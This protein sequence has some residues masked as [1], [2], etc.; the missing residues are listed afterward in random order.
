M[1]YLTIDGDVTISLIQY[2]GGCN[3]P[4]SGFIPPP[5]AP[6]PPLPTGV[7]YPPNPSAFP[8]VPGPYG[9]PMPPGPGGHVYQPGY[10][11]GYP[12]GGYPVS[13][14]NLSYS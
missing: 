3:V 5:V 8:P 2:E 12:T 14:T 6:V 11:P 7:P 1:T 10:V 13:I 9:T 4:G